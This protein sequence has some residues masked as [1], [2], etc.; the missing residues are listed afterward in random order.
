MEVRTRES[1]WDGGGRYRG[2]VEGDPRCPLETITPIFSACLC[3][4]SL[5]LGSGGRNS[6]LGVSE[7]AVL[8]VGA[9]GN[10]SQTQLVILPKSAC[11]LVIFGRPQGTRKVLTLSFP[12]QVPTALGLSASPG[13]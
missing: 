5:S 6:C 1:L 12:S 11:K 10:V 8:K 13:S 4:L 2:S 7:E 3:S 9:K